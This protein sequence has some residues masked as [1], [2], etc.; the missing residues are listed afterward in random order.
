MIYYFVA[1]Y[2]KDKAYSYHA[3]NN[4]FLPYS[5]IYRKKY[6]DYNKALV[7]AKHARHKNPDKK[8]YIFVDSAQC[9]YS[10][11]IQEVEA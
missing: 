9:F 11:A 4:T 5:P 8:K 2:G 7:A 10:K 6:K 1:Y 3:D